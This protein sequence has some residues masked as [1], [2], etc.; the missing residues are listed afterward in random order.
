[1]ESKPKN[2]TRNIKKKNPKDI[3]PTQKGKSSQWMTKVLGQ[4][5]KRQSSRIIERIKDPGLSAYINELI[6]PHPNVLVPVPNIPLGR[7]HV[8]NVHYR[9]IDTVNASGRLFAVLPFALLARNS[10]G[11]CSPLCI[12]NDTTYSPTSGANV[13]TDT[14]TFDTNIVGSSGAGLIADHFTQATIIAGHVSISLSG[15]SNLN[16]KGKIYV[17][18]SRNN[19]FGCG[20]VNSTDIA[21]VY[22]NR[23]TLANMVKYQHSREVEIMN[24][25]D[26]KITYNYIPSWS[27][28][29][30]LVYDPISTGASWFYDDMKAFV[31]IIDAADPTTEVIFDISFIIQARPEPS[32]LNIYPTVQATSFSNPD[33]ILRYLEQDTSIVFPGMKNPFDTTMGNKIEGDPR[34]SNMQ[35]VEKSLRSGV[36]TAFPF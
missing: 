6:N 28:A 17:A 3:Q 14:T 9:T 32:Y 24:M 21:Q 22:A 2:N 13:F 34:I 15:V 12:V 20:A 31:F 10:I 16:K 19:Y 8:K 4:A 11:S 26:N 1:M 27:Y 18:E 5:R 35:Q 29:R 30:P 36:G 25:T 33:P 7:C 23:Y